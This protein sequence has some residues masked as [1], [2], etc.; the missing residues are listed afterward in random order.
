MKTL[1]FYTLILAIF[2]ACSPSNDVQ[3][4][5]IDDPTPSS[6][7]VNTSSQS[8]DVHGN[9]DTASINI[10]FVGNSL[11]YSNDLPKLVYEFAKTKDVEIST[12][13][14]AKPNYAIIDHLDN[15]SQVITEINSKKYDYV[16][17]QQG[18]SSQSEGRKLLFEGGKRFSEICK[19]NDAELV[20]FMVWP[21][22]AY[23]HTFDG[24]IKNHTEAALEYEAILSPVGKQWKDYFDNT[25]DFSYYGP[26]QFHPSLEGSNAAAMIIFDTLLKTL[27]KPE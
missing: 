4:A 24:V 11:T 16:V 7:N 20:F 15:G 10:L 5:Q 23:Y 1:Y 25:G 22:R 13:M 27:Q 12:K 18:P 17:I 8:N 14:I 6:D 3:I 2:L 19:K 9:P 21:S 26:D